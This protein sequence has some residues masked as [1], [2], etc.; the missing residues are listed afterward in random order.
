MSKKP[1]D[2]K[3]P[4]NIIK[5]P[6]PFTSHPNSTPPAARSRTKG[7]ARHP[8]GYHDEVFEYNDGSY[9]ILVQPKREKFTVERMVFMAERLKM[10]LFDALPCYDDIDEF[11]LE[12]DPDTPA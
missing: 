10:E 12:L 3:P 8:R 9:V 1:Q 7:E 2:K 6:K 4:E 5:F 11:M